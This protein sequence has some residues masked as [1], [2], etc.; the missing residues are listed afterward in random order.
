MKLFECQGCGQPLY[1]E[2][3]RCESCGRRLGYLPTVQE[4]TALEGGDGRW[5]ALADRSSVRLCA[6]AAHDACNWLIPAAEEQDFCVACR[7]N[8]TVPN[9]ASDENLQRWR[10]L[11]IAK[12]R[13]FYTLMHLDL[14][15]SGRPQDPQ[16]LAF[17]F[18]ADP[19]DRPSAGPSIL[20]GHDNGL[21]TINIAEADDAERE[22]RR[23]SMGEP[24]RT[25][26]GH[27]RHEIG[28]YYW[29]VL[30]RDKPE[31]ERFR[32]VFGDERE[33]YGA[34]LERHYA[35][36]PRPDWP[37]L[38][39]SAYAGSHPWEDFAETWAHYLHIVDTLET[40]SAFGI[41]V[42]PK[43]GRERDLAAVIA[44]D[45]HHPLDFN[46]LIEAWLPLAFAVNSL[47]RSMGQPDLYPFVLSPVVVGKL[48]YI[49]HLVHRTADE[50]TEAAVLR[51]VAGGLRSSVGAPR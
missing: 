17:D 40:A 35:R 31:I 18:L 51:A 9:L 15:L 28:H 20:T 39:V 3:D 45:P 34:A 1:F 30:V 2:N 25:L 37:D 32:Q 44:F 29:N 22:R 8:R 26:L 5:L 43:I 48:A 10:R 23:L 4:V 12:R 19:N 38:F 16:G 21:I 33:D 50:G 6:N 11:E 7:H 36:G 13:L 14:P 41:G 46:R 42:S 24:Y 47:N 49:H 27:L